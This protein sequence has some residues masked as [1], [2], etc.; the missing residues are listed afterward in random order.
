MI[1]ISKRSRKQTADKI[2][3]AKLNFLKKKMVKFKNQKSAEI[4]FLI[5]AITAKTTYFF[6]DVYIWFHTNSKFK[7][8][9]EKTLA[10]E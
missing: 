6:L 9:I 7:L 3:E 4:K 2:L 10:A 5:T 1:L 8:I